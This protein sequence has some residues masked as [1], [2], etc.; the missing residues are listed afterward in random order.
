M[1]ALIVPGVLL[2][3]RLSLIKKF[4]WV[5]FFM[6]LPLVYTAFLYLGETRKQAQFMDSERTGLIY[7]K[8]LVQLLRLAQDHRD[9]TYVVA[10]GNSSLGVERLKTQEKIPSVIA[11]V[12]AAES[13]FGA[14]Y[15]RTP[16]WN[17]TRDRLKNLMR[18]EISTDSEREYSEHGETISGIRELIDLVTLKSNLI[19]DSDAASYH[20]MDIVTSK[21]P[22]LADRLSR[23][24]SLGASNIMRADMKQDDQVRMSVAEE[25]IKQQGLALKS[26]MDTAAG[27]AVLVKSAFVESPKLLAELTRFEADIALMLS[28]GA[29]AELKSAL[30]FQ[31]G[32]RAIESVYRI[33][34][35][36]LPLLDS[37][38]EARVS[39][40]RVQDTLAK[41]VALISLLVAIYLFCAFYYSVSSGI[42][43]LNRALARVAEG[44]LT[45]NIQSRARDEIGSVTDSLKE[46]QQRLRE[47]TLDIN[48]AAEQVYLASN[49][50]AD[51]NDDLA[52]RTEEQAST[53]EQTSASLE[54]LTATVQRN[55]E[56]A[57]DANDLTQDSA[58]IAES[59][60]AAMKQVVATM[61][62]IE[63]S[64]TQIGEIISLMDGIAFQRNILALNAAIEAARAGEQGRGFAVVATEVRN[65][66]RHS[67][68]AA[69]QIKGLVAQ[70]RA[71]VSAGVISV[72]E[73]LKTIQESLIG[74]KRVASFMTEIAAAS[75]EQSDGIA[76]VNRAVLQMDDANQQ[77]AAM[78]EEA[79]ATTELLKGQ[80]NALVNAVSRFKV[81]AAP[82]LATVPE[83]ARIVVPVSRNIQSVPAQAIEEWA[84]F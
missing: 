64:A 69:K 38:I 28:P 17:Q 33:A 10:K 55:A 30:F 71:K 22:D 29:L 75:H 16:R 80:A 27:E 35:I 60:R 20:L 13:N 49:Q 26:E 15:G 3:R 53:L 74:I 45:G 23:A 56:S 72:E 76:Q 8:P 67:A 44:D 7:V 68:D 21:I 65:L 79:G 54:E 2:M 25:L 82:A 4:I 47:L 73:T 32:S 78:V 19:L 48:R 58:N 70:T 9:F 83:G 39:S 37:L 43:F 31:S 59:G 84:E 34:D 46:A 81:A 50:I 57:N 51:G 36:A 52:H 62:E 24:R 40:Y 11:A 18:P 6:L 42:A 12:D 63:A 41:G 66:A 77:N 14:R 5:S 1:R 61:T